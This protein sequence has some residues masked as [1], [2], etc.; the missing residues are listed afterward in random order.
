M[1][2]DSSL[3]YG[4]LLVGWVGLLVLG[5]RLELGKHASTWFV[6]AAFYCVQL[7]LFIKELGPIDNLLFIVLSAICALCTW[8]QLQHRRE[9]EL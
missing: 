4:C 7:L 3:F 8:I 6:M 5:N 1:D 2:L 9:K